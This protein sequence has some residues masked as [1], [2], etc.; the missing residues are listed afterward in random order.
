VAPKK[1]L[2]TFTAEWIEKTLALKTWSDKKDKMT[3]IFTEADVPKLEKGSYID[4]VAVLKK[5]MGDSH[6]GV[7]QSAVKAIGALAKGLR[8]SFSELA[9][10][11]Y[12]LMLQR[13]KEKRLV[14]ELHTALTSMMYCVSLNDILEPLQAGLKD[15][16]PVIKCQCAVFLEKALHTTYIDVLEDI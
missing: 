4:L 9:K 2:A 14:E 6:I 7:A 16:S 8:E 11:L 10:E 12:P 13:F 3:E 1:I 5:F 15:K